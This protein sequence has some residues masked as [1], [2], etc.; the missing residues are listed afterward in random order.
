MSW[1]TTIAAFL[2]LATGATVKGIIGIGLPMVAIPGLALI[3][4]L[5]QA[6]AVVSLPVLAAN[7]WQVWQFRDAGR[8][9]RVIVPFILVGGVGTAIGTL[10]LVS[11]PEAWLELAL[12]AMLIAY[13]AL[14]LLSPEISLSPGT[15]RRGAAPTGL[16]AGIL[17]GA[18]GISGPI[19]IT[20]FHAQRPDRP[21][22]IFATGAMFAAF[23]LV[24]VPMLGATGILGWEAL[25][26]G[27]VSLPAVAFGLWLGNRLARRVDQRLFDRLVLVVLAWTAGALL[28]RGI[29]GILGAT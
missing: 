7:L 14:R 20:F 8:G 13:I 21:R 17:H 12:A 11:L 10:I 24:Q 19:G 23:T 26:A 16:A 9:D 3:I 18:T 22:F 4:G 5:P 25:T 27:I 1:L 15:A 6:L 29:G 28:W 2:L